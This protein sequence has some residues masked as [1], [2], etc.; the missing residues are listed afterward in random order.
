MLSL[1]CYDAECQAATTQRSV[2]GVVARYSAC[3]YSPDIRH[4][5]R[6]CHSTA[7]LSRVPA[8]TGTCHHF[9]QL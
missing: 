6:V 7:H 4:L 5:S 2:R 8:V 3:A 9:L 1:T